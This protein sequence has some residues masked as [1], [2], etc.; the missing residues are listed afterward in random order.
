MI[1][2]K[3]KKLT[4]DGNSHTSLIFGIT[5][6]TNLKI[7]SIQ[8]INLNMNLREL[9]FIMVLLILDIIF[10]TLRKINPNGFNLMMKESDNMIQETLKQ[11]A[12]VVKTGEDNH[13]AHTFLFMK[14]S[15]KDQLPLSFRLKNKEMLHFYSL[16]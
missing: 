9:F 1:N 16:D 2:S 10:L 7:T 4:A 8:R 3:I 6:W 5:L 11:T 14:K 12:M 15:R 13:K